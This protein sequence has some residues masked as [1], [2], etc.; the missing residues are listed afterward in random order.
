M[1][2]GRPRMLPFAL[3][4]ALIVA[5]SAIVRR[6]G[7]TEG[8]LASHDV[9][10]I[11]YNAMLLRSGGLPYVDSVEWKAP[12]SFY[13][14]ALLA[15]PEGT[16]IAALQIAANCVALGSLALVAVLAWRLWGPAAALTAAAVFALHDAHLDSM[17]AN[18]V[19]WALL[20]QLA[21]VLVAVL[22]DRRRRAQ[23]VPSAMSSTASQASGAPDDADPQPVPSRR[24][25]TASQASGTPDNADP[26]PVPSR[27]S[28]GTW[29]MAGVLCAAATL[30]KQPDG[31]V[32]VPVLAH[33][34]F[35]GPRR[36]LRSGLAVLLGFLGG[37]AVVG[38]HYL[39]H[40]QLGA[41]VASYTGINW[42]IA[43][44]GHH[45]DTPLRSAAWEGAAASLYFLALPL[46]LAGF[47]IAAR[48][49][50]PS[51][52]TRATLRLLAI[53]SAA[54]LVSAAVGLRFYKG[55]F[56]AVLPPLC[57]LAAA[58]WGLLSAAT[59]RRGLARW[60][61]APVLALL[62]ARAALQLHAT[63]VDRAHPHDDGARK[64]AAHIARHSQPGDRIWVW[65]WHLWGVYAYSD[66]LSASPLYKT[67]GLLTRFDNDTWRRP[68]TPV[69]F[70]PDSP[71]AARLLRDLEAAPPIFIALG[72]TVPREQF[73]GLRRFLA[74]RYERD[75]R[76]QVGKVE[77]WR[78]R[79]T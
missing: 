47:A 3:A 25:F 66:R 62:V 24:S 26:Q 49:R 35:A 74:A 22:A 78:R 79:E 14:A 64:I 20:P 40:G 34:L 61:A 29:L 44:I 76:I 52:E 32:L 42:G 56:L 9:G 69:Q 21:A 77:I 39:A 41:L 15:G 27:R 63:R 71:H 18:Y 13:L 31:I 11:L 38:A 17:D 55:Y 72:G 33:A 19:T 60:F 4:T 68:S 1:Q 70:I 48:P 12:G 46:V 54:A 10:G 37:H 5:I 75:R 50:E 45:A 73:T 30:C 51:P 59:W 58:P 53:W 65:G 23:P 6:P 7:F 2:P 67:P 8:G 57:L 28:F 16:D 43:Y 36:D